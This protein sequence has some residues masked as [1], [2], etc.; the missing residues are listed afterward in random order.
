MRKE[1]SDFLNSPRRNTWLSTPEMAVYLRK[2]RH[3]GS[4]GRI[5]TFLDIASI[6]VQPEFRDQGYF[7]AFLAL[8]Q[9]IIPYDGILI[10][11][12][13]SEILHNYLHRLAQRDPWWIE[14]EWHFRWENFGGA[15][16][17]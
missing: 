1:L 2:G 17:I 12:V 5:H 7:K 14:L 3:L 15:A 8:C 10:E 16:R 11:N 9:E 13:L 6:E 4:D